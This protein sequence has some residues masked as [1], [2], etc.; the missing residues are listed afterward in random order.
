MFTSVNRVTVGW[1]SLRREEIVSYAIRD[2]EKA[3][4]E[5]EAFIQSGSAARTFRVLSA[6]VAPRW[7]RR[8]SGCST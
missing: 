1:A 3:E 5:L 8:E 2:F 4:A 6:C 7:T